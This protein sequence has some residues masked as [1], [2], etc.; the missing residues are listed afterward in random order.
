MS[1][2]RFL[3]DEDEQTAAAVVVLGPDTA[4]ELF[5]ATDP[6]GETVM[7]Q[8]HHARGG[9]RARGTVVLG[10]HHEQR[11]GDRAGHDVRPATRRWHHPRF[12]QLD[13][14]EGR[15]QRPLSAAYQ[16]AD[17][18][19]MNLHGITTADDADFSIATQE[20]IIER[21]QPRSTTR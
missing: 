13:L 11:H 10:R 20:S 15:G 5:G 4:E 1:S 14:P 9:R 21:G 18:L 16:E 6:V 12:G 17:A 3:T 7:L 2:G 8:R 19:L